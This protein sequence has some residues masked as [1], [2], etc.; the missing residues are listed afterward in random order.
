GLSYSRPLGHS[1]PDEANGFV[2]DAGGHLG[3]V[4]GGSLLSQ[5]NRLHASGYSAGPLDG[6]QAIPTTADASAIAIDDQEGG[7]PLEGTGS[8]LSQQ[9][10][11]W[12]SYSGKPSHERPG[13]WESDSRQTPRR[14]GPH[15]DPSMNGLYSYG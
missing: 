15:N 7:Y 11:S 4:S 9:T 12:A 10:G 6:F 8:L 3:V 2:E 14:S 13:L 5:V 1:H